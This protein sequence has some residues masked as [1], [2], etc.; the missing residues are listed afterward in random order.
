MQIRINSYTCIHLQI[1]IHTHTNPYIPFN[2][3]WDYS[4]EINIIIERETFLVHVLELIKE[5]CHWPVV[6]GSDACISIIIIIGCPSI[7]MKAVLSWISGVSF[8]PSFQVLLFSLSF[9]GVTSINDIFPPKG[10]IFGITLPRVYIHV[11][12]LQMMLQNIFVTQLLPT[13][14]PFSRRQFTGEDS[15][16]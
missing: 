15:F 4:H 12:C 10:S 5:V 8:P 11:S 14:F 13:T 6:N 16:W 3:T 9:N 7:L 2:I 1:S